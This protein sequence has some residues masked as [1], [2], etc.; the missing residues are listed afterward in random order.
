MSTLADR[1]TAILESIADK[2]TAAEV[3]ITFI[4]AA[5]RSE[6]MAAQQEADERA[7]EAE[8]R[9]ER[10]REEQAIERRRQK[11]AERQKR[12]RLSRLSRVTGRDEPLLGVTDRDVV[13]P[14]DPPSS[15]GSSSLLSDPERAIPG[16]PAFQVV[17]GVATQW[18]ATEALL[19]KHQAAFPDLDVLAEYRKCQVYVEGKP[20]KRKT[21]QGMPTALFRW[22]QIAQESGKGAQRRP[23]NET[24][25]SA[26]P[27]GLEAYCQWHKD[28]RNQAK[29]SLKPKDTC[30]DCKHLKAASRPRAEGDTQ[31]ALGGTR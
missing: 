1:V 31:M 22:L 7:K 29:P 21:P 25:A 30:P 20:R 4:Q 12:H 2:R 16:L 10:E 6:I 19:A 23:T 9:A 13:P 18:W 5:T 28:A 14:L 8:R 11:A 26:K 27:S 24:S 17:G 15:P 3:V